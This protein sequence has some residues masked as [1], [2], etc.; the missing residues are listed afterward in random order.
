MVA[1]AV[2]RG[3]VQETKLIMDSLKHYPNRMIIKVD[4][5]IQESGQ[6]V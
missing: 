5:K 4:E 2:R 3:P 1:A 6:F